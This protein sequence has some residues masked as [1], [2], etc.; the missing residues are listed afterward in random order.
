MKSTIQSL[1]VS[2][3]LHATEDGERV[4]A[5]VRGLIAP[6]ALF[7][8][9]QMEGHFGN[10]IGKV[11]LHLDGEEATRAFGALVASM[12]GTLRRQ[13]AR[14]IDTLVDEHSSLY[15]RLDK[16]KLVNGTVDAGADDAVRFKV[17]PR[18]FLMH[19]H[20]RDFFRGLLE[21]E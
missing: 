13:F 1:E 19:G 15:L 21:G 2:F 10:T 4:C 14:D 12:P 11:G 16:Q 7:K 6:Q 20:A 3:L 17:K 5:A 8:A 9:E 18:A